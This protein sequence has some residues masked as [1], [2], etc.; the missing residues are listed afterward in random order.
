M[1]ALSVFRRFIASTAMLV[2]GAI[3]L[4]SA[5]AS[6]Q[7]TTAHASEALACDPLSGS[8][9][10]GDTRLPPGLSLD[11]WVRICAVRT[12]SRYAVLRSEGGY[13]ALN[14]EQGWV[15]RFDGRGVTA[16]PR[17]GDWTWGLQ[18][19]RVGVATDQDQRVMQYP[20]G[21]HVSGDR[22]EYDWGFGLQEWWINA[23]PGL[24]HGFSISERQGQ[25]CDGPLVFRLS[26]RGSLIPVSHADHRGVSF[27]DDL[28]NTIVDYAGLEVTDSAGLS[29]PA[30]IE[31]TQHEVTITV[32][33]AGACYPLTIDPLAQQVYL[34]ASK[35]GAGDRFGCSVSMS[36]D[37]L[38]VG[39]CKEDS[40]S[41]G[42]NGDELNDLAQD[43][44]AA[45]VFVRSGLT[46]VQQAYLKASNTDAGDL[47]GLCVSVSGDMIIVGAP[48]EASATVG[49]NGNQS[50]NAFPGAGAA[51]VFT[52]SGTTWTQAAY[53]KSSNQSAIF[54]I[55]VCASGD[56]VI[57]GARDDESASTGV[58]G[59]Q[60]SAGLFWAGAAYVF[61]RS[62]T[63]WSQ[64]AYLKASNTE[65]FDQF[66]HSVA[67]DGNTAVVGAPGE[68]SSAAGI[69]GDQANNATAGAGAAYVFVRSGAGWAQQA[70]LKASNPGSFDN[71]GSAL[72]C[73]Q[74]TI[75]IGAPDEDS[76]A[77]GVNGSQ[78]SNSLL[79]AGAA[80]VFVR[81]GTMWTQQAY[82]KA[83]NTG[84]QDQFA[85]SVCV[86]DNTIVVGAPNEA[87]SATGID[88]V[89]TDNSVGSAGAAYVFTRSGSLWSQVAYLKPA[90]V[91]VSD[92]F[93]SAICISG[94]TVAVGIPGEASSASGVNANQLDNSAPSAGAAA[95]FAVAQSYPGFCFGDGSGTTCPCGNLGMAGRGCPNSTIA[96]GSKLETTG[97]ASISL[98]SLS[99]RNSFAS[100]FGP[101]LYIQ[102]SAVPIA[103]GHFGDGLLCLT[104]SIS[105]LEIRFADA[106]G[107]SATTVPLSALGA[108]SSGDVRYYQAWYRDALTAC[109]GFGF[110]L[111]NAIAVTWLP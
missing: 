109:P 108:V 84:A 47:F 98:D 41:I 77:T 56:T 9:A 104:G 82:L 60:T 42:V 57:V 37:T 96:G 58:N 65:Q 1:G 61:V 25:S 5:L 101:G 45:Y 68:D 36:G 73:A 39:A 92:V 94:E 32:E 40:A 70:Y 105:R 66:G 111:S 95:V 110:N 59:S 15:I 34:K 29:L 55:S 72:S 30:Q 83:S 43:S 4:C 79:S 51:Y 12:A 106:L 76:A 28:G 69:D 54:G 81:N 14:P 62:G 97:Y 13:R 64:E 26:A 87:S 6:P 22:L 88:G 49:V 16:R 17:L 48:G 38:V 27:T 31:V 93:G 78:A 91:G 23:A 11:D 7:G 10:D 75:V 89:Q 18:L 74:D 19:E 33:D 85:A 52:R 8:N 102:G 50:N 90:T 80:Y 21:V 20:V 35:P 86:V 24:E 67:L 107:T 3:G 63:F 99:L 53:L 103:G 46:W 100:P 71:F 44:G 2:P